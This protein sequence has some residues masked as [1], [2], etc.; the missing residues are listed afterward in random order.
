MCGW[1]SPTERGRQCNRRDCERR[2]GVKKG[3]LAGSETHMTSTAGSGG[4][5]GN[6]TIS[7][8]DESRACDMAMSLGRFWTE[9][10]G[11]GHKL[12]LIHISEPTRPY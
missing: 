3:R 7:K 2:V 1:I 11:G 8:T 6:Q 12:S 4:S 5:F 10:E 9:R